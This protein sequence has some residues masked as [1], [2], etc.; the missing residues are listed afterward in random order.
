MEDPIFCKICYDEGGVNNTCAC[1]GTQGAVHIECLLTWIEYSQDMVCRDCNQSFSIPGI[2]IVIERNPARSNE[3]D[4]RN[5]PLNIENE[6]DYTRPPFRPFCIVFW[7]AVWTTTSVFAVG[8]LLITDSGRIS[9][10]AWIVCTFGIIIGSVAEFTRADVEPMTNSSLYIVVIT[11]WMS[12]LE[13]IMLT[14]CSFAG[15]EMVASTATFA[16]IYWAGGYSIA[17]VC[18]WIMCLSIVKYT[19]YRN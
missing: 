17:A 11:G 12:M 15:D 7:N 9:T 3:T 5:H 14:I 1:R 2:T 4:Y 16:R 10:V 19:C 18:S 13:C 8:D 6:H